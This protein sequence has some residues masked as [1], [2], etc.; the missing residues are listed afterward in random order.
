MKFLQT[1]G[2]RWNITL[3]HYR[4]HGAADGLVL[5]GFEIQPGSETD[6]IAH[7]QQL[8]YQYREQT[9]NPAYKFFLADM[10][11]RS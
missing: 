9:D 5:A 8:G 7:L 3:F 10:H 2:E 1:L 6:F 4:N 11:G